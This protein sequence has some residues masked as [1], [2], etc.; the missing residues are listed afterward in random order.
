MPPEGASPED[1]TLNKLGEKGVAGINKASLK[2]KVNVPVKAGDI[3]HKVCRRD[4]VP[5]QRH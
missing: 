5:K 2:R 3:V 1:Q 4:H